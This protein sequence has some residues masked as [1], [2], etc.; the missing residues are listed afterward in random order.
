[1]SPGWCLSYTVMT[2]GTCV[3]PASHPRGG[4]KPFPCTTNPGGNLNTKEAAVRVL[5]EWGEGE[6]EK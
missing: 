3:S 5:Q 1:M 2:C 4:P 6:G